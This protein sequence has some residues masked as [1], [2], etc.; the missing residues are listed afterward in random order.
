VSRQVRPSGLPL[1]ERLELSK[2]VDPSGCWL[3]TLHISS[4]GYGT[5][6]VAG[7]TQYAHRM[8]YEVF[9]GPIPVSMTVHHKCGTRH[10]MNPEHLELCSASENRKRAARIPLEEK[11][12]RAHEMRAQGYSKNDISVLLGMNGQLVKRV[13][14]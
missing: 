4:K 8:A 2:V 12:V 5:I 7:K 9:V 11:I 1:R 13:L 10:C 3:W 14:G 6:W